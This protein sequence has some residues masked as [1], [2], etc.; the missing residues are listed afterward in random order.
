MSSLVHRQQKDLA[1]TDKL[2]N[3]VSLICLYMHNKGFAASW[4]IQKLIEMY[5][6]FTTN[7]VVSKVLTVVL[8]RINL[9]DFL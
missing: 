6:L 3:T 8:T 9:T 1:Q 4:T 2:Y 5:T 7:F